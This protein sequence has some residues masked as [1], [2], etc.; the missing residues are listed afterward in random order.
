LSLSSDRRQTSFFLPAILEAPKPSTEPTWCLDIATQWTRAGGSFDCA[1]VYAPQGEFELF[2]HV[3]E[4]VNVTNVIILLET[5]IRRMGA[6]A[7]LVV[8]R[9]LKSRLGRLEKWAS[10]RGL[11]FSWSTTGQRRFPQGSKAGATW[12]SMEG[13][14]DIIGNDG[15]SSGPDRAL[16]MLLRE[17]EVRSR[18]ASAS[19]NQ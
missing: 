8:P 11:D 10:I 9:E 12:R 1:V 16:E 13:A 7:N 5:A 3:G 18:A 4:W 19:S 2:S 6:P 17:E 15:W 14:A